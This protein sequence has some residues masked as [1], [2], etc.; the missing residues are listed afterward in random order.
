M[1]GILR[2][3]LRYVFVP[4]GVLPT[5]KGASLTA[6][7]RVANLPNLSRPEILVLW[8][9]LLGREPQLS[10]IRKLLARR[11]AYR[12]PGDA[13]RTV[14]PDLLERNLDGDFCTWTLVKRGVK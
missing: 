2:Y 11:L 9:E 12:L 13:F 3:A 1:A 14:N 4:L 8:R 5:A 10:N 6:V 7:G